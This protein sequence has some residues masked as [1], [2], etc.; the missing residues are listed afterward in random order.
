VVSLSYSFSPIMFQIVEA[1]KGF[2]QFL[3]SVCAIVGGVFTVRW[4]CD[5]AMDSGG[6]L[7][8]PLLALA[9]HGSARLGRVCHAE[10][11]V[12]VAQLALE[13]ECFRPMSAENG[14]ISTNQKHLF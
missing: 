11:V 10:Q 5:I 7:L 9:D 6:T 12:V 1:R 4:W 14:D 2:L 8:I 13:I 3:T